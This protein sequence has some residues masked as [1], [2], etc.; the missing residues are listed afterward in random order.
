M[1]QDHEDFVPSFVKV[2]KWRFSAITIFGV[3]LDTPP[4]RK[5]DVISGRSLWL[6]AFPVAPATRFFKI[7]K[8]ESKIKVSCVNYRMIIG[9][10]SSLQLRN[11]KDLWKQFFAE[12]SID[13]TLSLTSSFLP[14]SFILLQK[15]NWAPLSP[16]NWMPSSIGTFLPTYLA[17]KLCSIRWKS[18]WSCVFISNLHL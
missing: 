4:S 18:F 12:S 8:E 1:C 14:L 6:H 10:M 15:T 5:S 3:M 11:Y 17:L 13:V 16:R 7:G 2:H 9:T